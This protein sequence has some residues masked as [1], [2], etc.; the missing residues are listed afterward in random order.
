MNTIAAVEVC[1]QAYA[2]KPHRQ[3]LASDSSD[4]RDARAIG[5]AVAHRTPLR[6]CHCRLIVG[7]SGKVG[8]RL[9]VRSVG[10][11]TVRSGG[12]GQV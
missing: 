7:G 10:K 1:L 6:S 12:Q 8:V 5:L 11:V 3:R 4:E 2:L 9:S